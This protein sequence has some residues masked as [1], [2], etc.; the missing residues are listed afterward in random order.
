M[1]ASVTAERSKGTAGY[2]CARPNHGL[3]A[4][5]GAV[6][7]RAA[8]A[9]PRAG[10]DAN[11]GCCGGGWGGGSTVTSIVPMCS[12]GEL[13]VPR[14]TPGEARGWRRTSAAESGSPPPAVS[15][16]G[17][18]GAGSGAGV[19]T[20]AGVCPAPTGRWPAA[21]RAATGRAAWTGP[22]RRSR[23]RPSVIAAAE[24]ARA[25]A[26]DSDPRDESDPRDVPGPRDVSGP[27]DAPE[28]R[29]ASEPC[30]ITV[31]AAGRTG[32][33]SAAR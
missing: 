7:V 29:N 9:A 20:P 18:D 3:P 6:A 17:P 27:C 30:A 21:A 25:A 26:V 1:R 22:A 24:P 10:R 5:W 12:R 14:A 2:L 33:G 28:L 11:S 31:G 15:C 32:G 23:R 8:V 19:R 13:F 4:T 16:R